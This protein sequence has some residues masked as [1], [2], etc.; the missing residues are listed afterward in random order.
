[1]VIVAIVLVV[2]DPASPRSDNFS[3]SSFMK[4]AA[5]SMISSQWPPSER[6]ELGLEAGAY[7]WVSLP[8]SE[9]I[10]GPLPVSGTIWGASAGCGSGSGCS[11]LTRGG[12]NAALRA[13]GNIA[14]AAKK[15]KRRIVALVA[16]S[17]SHAF[18]LAR[19]T[20][21]LDI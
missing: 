6:Q 21:R 12:S 5:F 13:I 19:R 16:I 9:P 3:A 14:A 17:A 7:C 2:V 20:A 1:M 10:W 18:T 8:V 11:K 4:S 15:I